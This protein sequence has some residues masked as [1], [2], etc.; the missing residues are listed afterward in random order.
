MINFANAL[1]IARVAAIPP[2]VVLMFSDL[3]MAEWGAV[4]LYAC[5]AFTDWLDGW[6][7]R[8]YNQMSEFG[9]FLDPI[10]DKILVGAMFIALTATEAINGWWLALPIIILTR[11]FLVSGLREFLGPKGVIVHVSKLAKWKTASQMLAL[12]F[13]IMAPVYINAA[14]AGLLL[15]LLATV[16][17]VVTGWDYLRSAKGHF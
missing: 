3:P 15:L 5:I 1:T 17:T 10:A 4:I 8:T 14:I 12:G 13:L 7:A 16:L 11:E 6:V 2:L 9:R